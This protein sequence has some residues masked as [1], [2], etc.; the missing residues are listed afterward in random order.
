LGGVIVNFARADPPQQ[1]RKKKRKRWQPEIRLSKTG[2]EKQKSGKKRKDTN[3]WA[4]WL[5]MRFSWVLVGYLKLFTYLSYNN[6]SRET[7]V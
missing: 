6:V 3:Q 7:I 5:K 2:A 4:S 1:L